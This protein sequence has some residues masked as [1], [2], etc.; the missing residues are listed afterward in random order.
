M[1]LECAPPGL[2]HETNAG[3]NQNQSLARWRWK[4]LGTNWNRW[5][6]VQANR[7]HRRHPELEVVCA[8]LLWQTAQ[9]LPPPRAACCKQSRGVGGSGREL[10]EGLA[11]GHWVVVDCTV[12]SWLS[13]V[14]PPKSRNHLRLSL[15][16]VLLKLSLLPISPKQLDRITGESNESSTARDTSRSR[17]SLSRSIGSR[18]VLYQI[19]RRM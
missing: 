12:I 16:R 18:V 6:V 15:L 13:L 5:Q 3:N 8:W 14:G 9:L 2:Q 7:K 17:D 11:E 4:S 1:A 19:S 10:N